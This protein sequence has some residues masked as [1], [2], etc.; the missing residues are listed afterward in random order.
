MASMGCKRTLKGHSNDVLSLALNKDYIY[1]Y[2]R[3]R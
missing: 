2:P 3:I 1:R